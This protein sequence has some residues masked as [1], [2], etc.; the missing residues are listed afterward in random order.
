M[1]G[2]QYD[3][4]N[5]TGTTDDRGHARRSPARTCRRAGDSFTINRHERRRCRDGPSRDTAEGATSLQR[6]DAGHLLRGRDGYDVVL[7]ALAAGPPVP[8]PTVLRWGS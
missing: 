8:I 4:T 6:G 3:N 1:I 7:T 5:V 2:T